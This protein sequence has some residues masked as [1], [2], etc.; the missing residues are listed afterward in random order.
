MLGPIPVVKT[1]TFDVT[2]TAT[3]AALNTASV[4]SGSNSYTAYDYT[5]IYNQNTW[6]GN[7]T[8]W[9]TNGNWSRNA[10]PGGSDWVVIPTN[11]SGGQMPL[12]S[13]NAGVFNLQIQP[14]ASVDLGTNALTVQ[15]NLDNQGTLKQTILSVPGNGQTSFLHLTNASGAQD[16]YF[17]LNLTPTGGAMGS[18]TVQIRGNA[19]C[20]DADPTDTVNRCYEVAPTTPQTA[21]V[22]FY[23]LEGELDGQAPGSLNAW[24]WSSGWSPAGTTGARGVQ[25]T[26][27]RWVDTSGVTAYSPFTLTE[28][29]S[30][31]TAVTLAS[32]SA[33]SQSQ[34]WLA[35]LLI[36][37]TGIALAGAWQLM[38][39]RKA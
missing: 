9:A 33:Q 30:G 34:P 19:Q 15:E 8:S 29:V 36:G 1:F 7:S 28:K 27:Y 24:H 20:T 32:L 31:P 18:T 6:L 2:A 13:G 17:G 26:G 23:Y 3:P 12:L 22:R 21:N 25:P 39:R 38:R 11:P 5:S 37:V 10:V 35:W 4:T 16:K 14:G